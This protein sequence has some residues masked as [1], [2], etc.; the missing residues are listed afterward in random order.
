MSAGTSFSYST[1]AWTLVSAVVEAAAADPFTVVMKKFLQ[2][3]GLK[4]TYLEEEEPLIYNRARY[5]TN[6]LFLVTCQKSS[7]FLIFPDRLS[8]TNIPHLVE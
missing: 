3:M 8:V 5:V 6:L 2:V 4:Y 7:K 1:H